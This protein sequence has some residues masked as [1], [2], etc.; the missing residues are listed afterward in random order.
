MVISLRVARILRFTEAGFKASPTGFAKL[1]VSLPELLDS[2]ED[3]LL[4]TS[5][6][7]GSAS[8]AFVAASGWGWI[9]ACAMRPAEANNATAVKIR[10][11]LR[12]FLEVS[13]TL[14]VVKNNS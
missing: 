6:A 12:Y 8:M 9:C 14:A 13:R 10:L 1:S 7:S 5:G 2:V 4:E 3:V 11:L